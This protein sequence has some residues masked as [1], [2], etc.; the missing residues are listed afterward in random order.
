MGCNSAES[1]SG[2]ETRNKFNATRKGSE[3]CNSAESLSGIETK[4]K[5]IVDPISIEGCNS[6]E[7]LSGIETHCRRVQMSNAGWVAI[8]LNPYQGLKHILLW[9]TI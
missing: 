5:S 8:V 9:L 2:I 3:C 6:A 1:L 7:S 4:H